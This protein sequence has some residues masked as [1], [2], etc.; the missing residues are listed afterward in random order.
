M[1]KLG[2]R[3]TSSSTP[4]AEAARWLRSFLILTLFSLATLPVIY[5]LQ[6]ASDISWSDLATLLFREKMLSIITQTFGLALV[7]AVA[8]LTLGLLFASLLYFL[9]LKNRS[10]FLLL[11]TL[12]LAIP[13]YVFTYT[14]IALFPSFR[15]FW[16]AA[17]VLTFATMPYV[18]LASFAGLRRVDPV[19]IEVARSLGFNR[20]ETLFKIVLPQIRSAVGASLLLVILYVFSDFGAVSLLGV[21]TFTRTIQNLYRASYDRQSA[22]VIGLIL[23]AIAA[24]IVLFE[25][26]IQKRTVSLR[27]S[28]KAPSSDALISQKGA[29]FAVSSL[30]LA[31]SFFALFIPL[32]VLVSRMVNNFAGFDYLSLF[33]ATVNTIF[34]ATLGA[35]IALIFTLP[36]AWTISINATNSLNS[37]NSLNSRN[38]FYR[39]NRLALATEKMV[40]ITHA[41]PGVVLGLSL[42]AFSSNFPWLYQSIA[43]LAFA[44]ALLFMAKALGNT[45]SSLERI[46]PILKDVSLTMGVTP[47]QTFKRVTLPLAAPGVGVGFLLVLLTAMKELPATLMLRPT[48]FET[49][50]LEIWSQSSLSRFNEA[51]PYALVLVLLAAIPTFIL[52]RPDRQYEV[53]AR[54]EWVREM[55]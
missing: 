43:L 1:V 34:V 2:S 35:L 53:E 24:S 18:L 50:A 49:L 32:Y 30:L 48:G 39:S 29:K 40:L 20:F 52:S 12:P 19:Q 7:V 14:Y 27:T 38:N 6:R 55:N 11:A 42:V 36:L 4:L 41:L 5:L 25:E 31:Y 16:A 46:S 37:L 22:A 13:S 47:W 33:S 15:G 21:D 54:Q 17:L 9:N 23:M 51:A 3:P 44:Y 26:R 45:R 10:L 28:V 8:A